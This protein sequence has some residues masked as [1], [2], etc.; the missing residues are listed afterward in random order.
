MLQGPLVQADK[1]LTDLLANFEQWIASKCVWR[2]GSARTR[3]G[4]YSAP[5]DKMS[6]CM[7]T[8]ASIRFTAFLLPGQF[9]PW[10]ESANRT[11]ANSLP[12]TFVPRSELVWELSLPG[13]FAPWPF[14]S[15]AFSLPGTFVPRS[16]LVW[17]L[18]LPGT[19]A[20]ESIRSQEHS[21]SETF[22]PC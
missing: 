8:Y 15:L 10:S 6:S 12:G 7:L 17:E 16:E 21:L 19:F 20:L 11:L 4:S 9:A 3:W 1:T 22:V 18:S 2:S 14:R 5:L 13:P